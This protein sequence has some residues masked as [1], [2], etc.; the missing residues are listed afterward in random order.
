MF[1]YLSEIQITV[2]LLRSK[3]LCDNSLSSLSTTIALL[4]IL[5]LQQY[6]KQLC[7]YN[8]CIF[9][10]ILFIYSCSFLFPIF[11]FFYYFF[12]WRIK[13][14]AKEY[15]QTKKNITKMFICITQISYIL[16]VLLFESNKKIEKKKK[17]RKIKNKNS[18][19][20]FCFLLFVAAIF[21][22]FC[23]FIL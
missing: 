6:L 23:R 5:L 18:N 20:K 2:D 10:F 4:R 15:I 13:H 14:D 12:C 21:S 9:Y 19:M 3:M 7:I 8:A 17:N 22:L 11:Y 1:N 16:L